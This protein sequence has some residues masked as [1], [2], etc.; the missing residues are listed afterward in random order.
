LKYQNKKFS[1]SK[2]GSLPPD[3]PAISKS[4]DQH[5]CSY[6]EPQSMDQVG[7]ALLPATNIPITH[8]KPHSKQQQKYK[9][10]YRVV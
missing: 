2:L 6:P 10:F 8:I 5:T 1:S 4:V 3:S 9:K 7:M